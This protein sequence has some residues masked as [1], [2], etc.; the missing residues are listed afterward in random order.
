M[1][2][3]WNSVRDKS[4]VSNLL[5]QAGLSWKKTGEFNLNQDSV[6]NLG[7][8][9]RLVM[10]ALELK[11]GEMADKVYQSRGKSYLLKL[12]KM[13]K[14]QPQQAKAELSNTIAQQKAGNVMNLWFEQ[15]RK[16]AKVQ[17]NSK[18]LSQVR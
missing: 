2:S 14:A 5:K 16:D 3:T 8:D 18:V 11:P 7:D 17:R 12:V 15:A 1:E 13:N 10:A 9:E 4:S 6:P